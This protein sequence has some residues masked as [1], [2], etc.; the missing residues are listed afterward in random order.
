MKNIF[1]LL[2]FIICFSCALPSSTFHHPPQAGVDFSKGKWLLNSL[3]VPS[4]VVLSLEK[5][6]LKDLSK[7]LKDRFMYYPNSKGFLLPQK[8]QMNPGPDLLK[9]IRKVTNFDYF[10]NIKAGILKDDLGSVSSKQINAFS[11]VASNS[12]YVEMEIY[13]LN[14]TLVIYSQKV[15][16]TV[17][18]PE[19][20]N[21]VV[22]SKSARDLI[23]NGYN[24]LFNDLKSKSYN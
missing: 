3:D 4:N 5:D 14:S 22:L 9:D 23:R 20:E 15:T 7:Q 6:V 1:T 10:I 8:I 21:G 13:D 17:T 11:N 16:S 2:I 12:V 19:N 24:K 18:R